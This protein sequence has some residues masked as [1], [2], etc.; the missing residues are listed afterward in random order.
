[1]IYARSQQSLFWRYL[2]AFDL[3]CA[4]IE[5]KP[6]TIPIECINKWHRGELPAID[7]DT[8]KQNPDS[9]DDRLLCLTIDALGLQRIERLPIEALNKVSR[10]NF[11]AYV[12]E[13]I[14][15]FSGVQVEFKVYLSSILA[16]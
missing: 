11:L 5:S 3:G 1:M 14:G 4:L 16:A 13:A 10:P 8:H 9:K 2:S 6:F 12:V 15:R 7:K